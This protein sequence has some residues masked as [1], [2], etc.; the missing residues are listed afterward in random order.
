MLTVPF[1]THRFS[2][3]GLGH[4]CC[5]LAAASLACMAWAASAQ[6]PTPP[7]ETLARVLETK[8]LVMGVREAARPFSYLSDDKQ[9]VGYAIDLCNAAVEELRR[10]LQLPD[11]QVQYKTVNGPERIP[12]LLSGEIDMECGA[13]TNTKARQ[14]QV[15]F[16]YTYFVGGMRV[17]S[18]KD[19]PIHSLNDLRGAGVALS[20]GTIS[21]KMF[22]RLSA[23]E[24]PMKLAVY[25]NNAEAYKAL[26]DGKVRAFPQDDSLLLG[27]MSADPVA[28]QRYQLSTF[29]LSVEPYAVMV[30]KQDTALL[31]VID[32]TLARLFASGEIKTLYAKW[33]LND[34]L[35]I[36]MSRLTRDGFLRPNKEPGVALVLAHSL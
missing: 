29:A 2:L 5:R 14:E 8:V 23:G 31:A 33:F 19:Q 36:Q 28:A 1:F 27:M 7:N 15:A 4:P 6:T 26:K 18:P 16:S 32:K 21:E 22:N 35:Q 24:V 10:E 12:K 20:K 11:L 25:G 34:T 3:R 9:S 13:T 30:R 17:L